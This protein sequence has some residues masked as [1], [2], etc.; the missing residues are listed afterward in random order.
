MGLILSHPEDVSSGCANFSSVQVFVGLIL[1]QPEDSSSGCANFRL[2]KFGNILR[3][4][5]MDHLDAQDSF[6][7]H[8]VS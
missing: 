6:R 8:S 7:G 5:K 3:N 2:G 4:Q 1:A